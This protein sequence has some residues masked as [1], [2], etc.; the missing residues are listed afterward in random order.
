MSM[1]SQSL[2]AQHHLPPVWGNDTAQYE[3][4]AIAYIAP[5]R[6]VWKS[7]TGHAT[8]S[9]LD[10]LLK[11]GIGQAV[12]SDKGYCHLKNGKTGRV[13]F[14][15][16]FGRELQGGIQIVTGE[17]LTHDVKVRVRFG[18]SA[19]EA[20]SDIDGKNG[21][22]NDH[23]IRDFDLDLPW[24]G[25]ANYGNSGFRFVRIDLL[26][27]DTD[28]LLREVR[29]S[30]MYNDLPYQGSFEC[31][32]ERLNKIWMTGAYTVQ[33][34]LQNYLW[35]GIKRDRLVW[36]GD[37]YPE[38][39][40][41]NTVFGYTDVVPRSLDL[42]R[43]LYPIPQWMNGYSSY[44]I[45]WLL[46]QYRWYMH[47]GDKNYLEQQH[48][49]ILSLLNLLM[50][51]IGPD[52][53]EKLDGGRFLDWPSSTNP[54]GVDAGLQAL[55]VLAMQTGEKL[56]GYLG[57]P[58]MAHKCQMSVARLRKYIPDCNKSKQAAALMSLAGT[59]NA[60]RG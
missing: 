37:I 20:M 21:A 16:D 28:L 59:M 39:E 55:M 50:D 43:D 2:F 5:R 44:S 23:A 38:V 56:C 7:V 19:S 48:A 11:P 35:D 54:K 3:S 22:T 12:L 46:T 40:T 31:S 15:L 58:E 25:V 26:G 4:R 14:L 18:E 6:I 1:M 33:L 10:C 30:F 41:V 45:W 36:I 52:G 17:S 13:S 51:K 29:A 9:G 57:E 34:N 27:E 49:Y 60:K 32:N 8:V 47:N 24:L 42:S 53:K